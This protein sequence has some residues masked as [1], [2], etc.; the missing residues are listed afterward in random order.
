MGQTEKDNNQDITMWTDERVVRVANDAAL[1]AL[2]ESGKKQKS[3]EL[4]ALAKEQYRKEHGKELL[5]TEKSLACEIY[6]HFHMKEKAEAFEKRFGKKKWTQ[7]LIRHMDP[8]D[9][10]DKKAD[11]N[12][13]LWDMLSVI[14]FARK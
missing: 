10:G 9:C 1:R 11:N 14:F 7:W 6:W 4:A 13:F 8:I 2:L 3:Y 5:I 12:R